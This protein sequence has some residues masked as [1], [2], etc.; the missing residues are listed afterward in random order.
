MLNLTALVL[1][2]SPLFQGIYWALAC[3]WLIYDG[4]KI[5]HIKGE[6]YTGNSSYAFIYTDYIPTEFF[7]SGIVSG[8]LT[9]VNVICIF[10]TAIVVLKIKEVASPYTSSPDLRRYVEAIKEFGI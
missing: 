3:I 4:V 7:I 2:L 5:P 6:P 9:I 1:T 10:I 8:L